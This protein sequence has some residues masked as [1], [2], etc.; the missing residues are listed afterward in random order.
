MSSIAPTTARQPFEGTCIAAIQPAD[1]R[2]IRQK[3]DF[4]DAVF[5][6]LAKTVPNVTAVI[7]AEKL[8]RTDTCDV[9]ID[10]EFLYRDIG[11]IRR[12]LHLQTQKDF[13]ER[14]GLTAAVADVQS[15]MRASEA[16]YDSRGPDGRP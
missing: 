14:I 9:Y 6:E 16:S 2:L 10:G 13:A 3:T 1:A 8:C 7:P 12:N 5:V 4:I 15:N 11:H